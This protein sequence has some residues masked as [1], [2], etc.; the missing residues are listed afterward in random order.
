MPAS[1]SET[2]NIYPVFAPIVVCFLELTEIS[3]FSIA[4]VAE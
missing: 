4:D 3:S 2:Q 1:Q